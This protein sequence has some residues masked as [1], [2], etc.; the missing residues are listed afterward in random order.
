ML[1]ELKF[2]KGAVSKKDLVPELTHFHIADGRVEG[3][4]GKLSLSAPIALDIDCC[5]RAEPF[6]RAIEACEGTAQ[7]HLTASGKL[8]VRSGKFRA[9]V[10]T[11]SADAFP[12]VQPEGVALDLQGIQLLPG[13][14]MLEPLIGTD[15]SR[16]WANGILL[17]GMSAYATNNVILAE[18]WMGCHFPYRVVIP[19][20]AVKE[21]LRIGEEP[22]GMQLTALNATF[23]FEGERWMRTQLLS[24]AWPNVRGMLDEY[25]HGQGALVSEEFWT[26]LDTLAPFSTDKFSAVYLE[27]N[28]V[29]THPDTEQGAFIEV[30]EQ[31]LMGA[32]SHKVLRL[33]N[34]I[35]TH[36]DFAAYPGKVSWHGE[37]TRGLIMGLRVE[38]VQNAA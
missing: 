14:R 31:G 19:L 12:G 30:P 7:L 4:N 21:L 1:S 8:S 34:G 20:N 24:D 36:V 38:A 22:I 2:V 11:V 37:V 3:F 29:R 33:L 10:E 17:D 27:G 9:L 6:I 16:P 32:Y 26:A 18:Y 23:H 5:P 35:A 15:A 28:V 13:M 25:A